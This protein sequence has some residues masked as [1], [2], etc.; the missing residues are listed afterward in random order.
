MVNEKN[1]IN[2]EHYRI[3]MICCFNSFVFRRFEFGRH[4]DRFSCYDSQRNNVKCFFSL[5]LFP[6]KFDV[7]CSNRIRRTRGIR[8]NIIE[9]LIQLCIQQQSNNKIYKCSYSM[10]YASTFQHSFSGRI[11]IFGDISIP[12]VGFK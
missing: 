9:M 6:K 5:G 2:I 7:S 11:R 1:V 12:A 8:L 3:L 4:S 10:R